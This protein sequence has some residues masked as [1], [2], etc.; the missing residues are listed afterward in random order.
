MQHRNGRHLSSRSVKD[1]VERATAKSG[2]GRRV[3]PHTFRH[4]IST[5]MQRNHADLRHIHAILGYTSLRTTQVYTH[6]NIEDLKEVV[7]RSIPTGSGQAWR[8]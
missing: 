3:S 6:A 8:L 2:V 7:R 1:I 4:A 5:H